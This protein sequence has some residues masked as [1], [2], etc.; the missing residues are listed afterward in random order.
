MKLSSIEFFEIIEALR[1]GEWKGGEGEGDRGKGEREGDGEGKREGDRESI[2]K[3]ILRLTCP[4]YIHIPPFTFLHQS[5][6][7]NNHRQQTTF[8]PPTCSYH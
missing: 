8:H 6:S 2:K 7:N 3:S 5:T 4:S 1:E